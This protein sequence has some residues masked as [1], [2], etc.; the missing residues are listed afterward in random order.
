MSREDVIQLVRA[1]YR[2]ESVL[3]GQKMQGRSWIIQSM[4]Y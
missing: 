3:K 2:R 4:N 1:G